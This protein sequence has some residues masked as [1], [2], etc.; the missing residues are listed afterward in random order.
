MFNIAS[1]VICHCLVVTMA[2]ASVIRLSLPSHKV[3]QLIRVVESPASDFIMAASSEAARLSLGPSH[4]SNRFMR[5]LSSSVSQ[6]QVPTRRPTSAPLATTTQASL[7]TRS[8]PVSTRKQ[9]TNQGRAD[10][11]LRF[12]AGR[13]SASEPEPEVVTDYPSKPYSMAF[14]SAD[15]N[16]TTMRRE[17]TK[18]DKGTIRGSYSYTDPFGMFRVVE[19]IADENGFR[20]SIRTNEPGVARTQNGDPAGIIYE[21]DPSPSNYHPPGS[22]DS[23]SRTSENL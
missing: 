21:V 13:A 15:G 8:P 1:S 11:S 18:D 14:D 4:Q 16:G 2:T 9:A 3:P 5:V 23:S 20:A 10:D 6:P 22:L 12:Q 17:E 7:V 19:Y